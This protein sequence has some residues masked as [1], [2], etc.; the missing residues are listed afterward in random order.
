MAYKRLITIEKVTK[1]ELKVIPRLKEFL[2][3]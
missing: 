3:M 2:K 1:G